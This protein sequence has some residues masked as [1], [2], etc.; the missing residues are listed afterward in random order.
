MRDIEIG[1]YQSIKGDDPPF[2]AFMLPRANYHVFYHGDTAEEAEA[3]AR[4]AAEEAVAKYEATYIARVKA[5]EK[6]RE[7]VKRKKESKEV[8]IPAYLESILPALEK[9]LTPLDKK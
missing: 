5:L 7:T 4:K 3:S 1:V 8:S 6:A 2:L 9:S